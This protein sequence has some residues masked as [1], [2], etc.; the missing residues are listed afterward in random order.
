[1]RG[2]PEPALRVLIQSP[3]TSRR[4]DRPPSL[5]PRVQRVVAALAIALPLPA[6][7]LH[8]VDAPPGV[9]QWS[10]EPWV[11]ALL[12]A[13][14][15]L[16]AMGIAS[17]W[18]RAG[19]GRGIRVAEAG[20]FAVGWLVLAVALLS[21]LDAL[22]ARS[23]AL[24]MVQHE[25]LMVVAAPL[26]VRSRPLEA[27]AWALSRWR[28]GLGAVTHNRVVGAA[29]RALT[30]LVGA[31]CFHAIA[32]WAWHLPA[33]FHAALSSTAV[34]ALQHATFLASALAFWWSVLD[35]RSRAPGALQLASVAA[36]MVH[37]GLLGALL[38]FA[39][40]PWYGVEGARALGLTPLEDQQLGG[41][42]MWVPG[43]LAYLVAGLAL[44]ASWLREG[45]PPRRRTAGSRAPT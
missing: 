24:H 2:V 7:A 17:L 20:R 1:M 6:L 15:A 19:A 25:L 45:P 37:T 38:T 18:R 42:V 22:A 28:G 10:F 44:A 16:Y 12:V 43:G 11:V 39:P 40:S 35:A 4:S 8:D 21:P 23:F 32:L 30:G 41:L 9:A 14:A 33:L 26:L 34:H 3:V 13:G 27:W 36:T 29:W 31:W 5:W